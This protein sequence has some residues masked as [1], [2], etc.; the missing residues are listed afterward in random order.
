LAAGRCL[1]P[2]FPAHEVEV[3]SGRRFAAGIRA[4]LP[5]EKV[6]TPFKRAAECGEQLFE[7]EPGE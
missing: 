3:R 4:F 1:S 5:G 6:K 2:G 7:A